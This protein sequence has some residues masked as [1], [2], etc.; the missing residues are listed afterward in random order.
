MVGFRD[1]LITSQSPIIK[2]IQE[3][4]IGGV[5]LYDYDSPSQSRPRN[6]TSPKQVKE[7]TQQLQS[8]SKIPLFIAI[9]EEGG[10]V[11]RLKPRYGFPPSVSAQYLGQRNNEDTTRFYAKRIAELCEVSGI[12]V[13]F[14]PVVDVNVNPD[15]PVI[16]KLERSFSTNP[17]SVAFHAEIFIHELTKQGIWPCVKHFPGHG[18]SAADSHLGFTDVSETWNESELLPY[19]KLIHDSLCP[20]VM[21][22]HVFNRNLDSVYPATLSK[23]TL[24]ILRNDLG[25]NG[26]IFS[27]DMMMK[28]IA[29]HYGLSQA[30]EKAVNGG[31]DV[32]IFSNNIDTYDEQIAQKV[33]D[34][35]MELVQSGK[36]SEQ[37]ID[38]SYQ[39]V[40]KVKDRLHR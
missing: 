19:K 6:I 37:R 31:V 40:M 24:D 25:F 4:K 8:Y 18:S 32:M 5:V 15:C 12:N 26:L 3:L 9:D 7:L 35:I 29:D 28:A 38:E 20:M 33:L 22:S 23:P 1:T 10:K 30:I 39:R 17:D 2:D 21:T 16:G 14:A 27:D 13:N 34:L 11:S 36:I